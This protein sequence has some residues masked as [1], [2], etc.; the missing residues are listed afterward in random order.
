M[1]GPSGYG[2]EHSRDEHVEYGALSDYS[3]NAAV[4][5]ESGEDRGR[6]RRRC[7]PLETRWEERVRAATVFSQSSRRKRRE[8]GMEWIGEQQTLGMD[9]P[10]RNGF[11]NSGAGIAGSPGNKSV[12]TNPNIKAALDN[13]DKNCGRKPLR[14]CIRG[15][16]P[17][18]W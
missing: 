11:G 17:P 15:L 12:L 13:Q 18:V 14:D 16:L 6:H 3:P 2:V 1:A 8:K 4:S 9:G 5:M 10:M 7:P